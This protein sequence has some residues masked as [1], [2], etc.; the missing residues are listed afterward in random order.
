MQRSPFHF[1]FRQLRNFRF[2][3]LTQ[4]FVN[5][6]LLQN[7][8]K[9]Q[10]EGNDFSSSPHQMNYSIFG[11]AEAI[12]PVQRRRFRESQRAYKT[13]QK[14]KLSLFPTK[15]GK[16]RYSFSALK[17][18]QSFFDGTRRHVAITEKFDAKSI[19]KFGFQQVN[20][21]SFNLAS[22]SSFK[23]A[24][25][26]TGSIQSIFQFSPSCFFGNILY[27]KENYLQISSTM[28]FSFFL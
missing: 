27:T 18:I 19:H 13:S 16:R 1:T 14:R 21:L 20:N 8:R 4:E 7:A 12:S 3:F 2:F 28:F 5:K 26:Q 11:N 25:N 9:I 6:N 24:R 10:T 15:R 23:E 17:P 22:S